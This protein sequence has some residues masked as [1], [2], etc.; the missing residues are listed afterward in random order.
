MRAWLLPPPWRQPLGPAP[1]PVTR[2]RSRLSGAGKGGEKPAGWLCREPTRPGARRCRPAATRGF[3]RPDC[4]RRVP[5][6]F[7]LPHPAGAAEP[8][9][10]AA[11]ASGRPGQA[12]RAWCGGEKIVISVVRHAGTALRRVGSTPAPAGSGQ[13]G[14]HQVTV[15]RDV[16]MAQRGD[17]RLA[18]SVTRASPQSGTGMPRHSGQRG[19]YKGGR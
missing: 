9:G 3:L 17:T 18:G 16:P 2:P 6:R 15:Q 5:E 4:G 14:C 19:G 10:Q 12:T 8:A 11:L 1:A 13:A 7:L